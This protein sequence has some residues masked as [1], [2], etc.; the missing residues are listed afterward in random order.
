MSVDA[1]LNLLSVVAFSSGHLAIK[2]TESYS[3]THIKVMLPKTYT[4]TLTFGHIN[5]IESLV[6]RAAGGWQQFSYRVFVP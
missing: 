2:Y 5:R 6:S 4:P 3:L 1:I